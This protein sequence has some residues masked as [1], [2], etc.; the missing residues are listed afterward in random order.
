VTSPLPRPLPTATDIQLTRTMREAG[1]ILDMLPVKRFL[2]KM[3]RK[4]P[5]FGR[6]GGFEA[7]SSL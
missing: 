3:A 4:A 1:K 6:F 5:Y 7:A 2:S